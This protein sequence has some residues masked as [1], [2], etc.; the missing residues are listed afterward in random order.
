MSFFEHQHMTVYLEWQRAKLC[1]G[2]LV[3]L[4]ILKPW[5]FL[6]PAWPCHSCSWLLVEAAFGVVIAPLVTGQPITVMRRGPPVKQ[7]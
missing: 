5:P 4:C 3:H 6:L 1:M 7:Q 2:Q